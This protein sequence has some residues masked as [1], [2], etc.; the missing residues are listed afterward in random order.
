MNHESRIPIHL[1]GVYVRT[2]NLAFEMLS[3]ISRLCSY[4][5]QCELEQL[6]YRFSDLNHVTVFVHILPIYNWWE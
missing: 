1:Y 5:L 6:N 4:H 2:Q 3:L